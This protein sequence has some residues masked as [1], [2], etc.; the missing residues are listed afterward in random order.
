MQRTFWVYLV[1][2]APRGYMYAGF[3]ND[4]AQRID[5]HKHGQADGYTREHGCDQLVWY[6]R[7]AYADRAI[8]REKQIKR[9]L[10]D[11]KFALVEEHNPQWLDLFSGLGGGADVRPAQP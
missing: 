4:L 1:A 2:S 7:H 6:E 9:W 5:E 11:W 8:K 3:T 10:R